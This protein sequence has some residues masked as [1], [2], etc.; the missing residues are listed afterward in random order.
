M[1]KYHESGKSKENKK[2]SD[3]QE[4]F[5]VVLSQKFCDSELGVY[6]SK[7]FYPEKEGWVL[8]GAPYSR[9]DTLHATYSVSSSTVAH[10]KQPDGINEPFYEIFAHHLY[11]S[12]NASVTPTFLMIRQGVLGIGSLARGAVVLTQYSYQKV[13]NHTRAEILAEHW[14][15]NHWVANWDWGVNK[16]DNYAYY[17][18]KN[19]GLSVFYEFDKSNILSGPQTALDGKL[20]SRLS[21]EFILDKVEFE[22]RDFGLDIVFRYPE[23]VKEALVKIECIKPEEIYKLACWVAGL[24]GEAIPNQRAYFMALAENTAKALIARKN[25]LRAWLKNHLFLIWMM[26]QSL[27]PVHIYI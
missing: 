20:V 21:N 13:C 14:V 1:E 24:V 3:L 15:Y 7:I 19:G 8:N 18:N 4:S 12:L 6:S 2:P 10:Y 25:K 27:S 9:G 16:Y 22:N 11:K 5:G 17:E 26:N 23:R